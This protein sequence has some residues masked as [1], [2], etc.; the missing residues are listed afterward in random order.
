M[1]PKKS[2]DKKMSGGA[3]KPADSLAAIGSIS[4]LATKMSKIEEKSEGSDDY[5]ESDDEFEEA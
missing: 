4:A 3:S 1:E 2:L 5:E